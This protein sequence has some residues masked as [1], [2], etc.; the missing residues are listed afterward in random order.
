MHNIVYYDF[1]LML[2]FVNID[3]DCVFLQD[4]SY[5]TD[6]GFRTVE[7]SCKPLILKELRRLWEKQDSTLPWSIGEYDETNTL[8]LEHSPYKALL[9]PVSDLT[10]F[11]I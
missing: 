9:N 1:N 4:Q 7:N 8:L 5:C 11:C 2:C 3:Q 6:T 10:F